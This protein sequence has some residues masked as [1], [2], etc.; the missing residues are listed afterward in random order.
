[1]TKSLGFG[2]ISF[3]ALQLLSQEFVL[4]DVHPRTD[5]LLDRPSAS[6]RAANATYATNL[7]I[8]PRNAF[9]EVE[10]AMLC[11]HLPNGFHDELPIFGVYQRH[12]LG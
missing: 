9:R 8:R 10:S 11:K 2:Q 4:R 1:V 12:I 7:S 3:A 6:R 5:K